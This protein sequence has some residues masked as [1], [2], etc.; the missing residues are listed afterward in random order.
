MFA[1]N[2]AYT[3]YMKRF[4]VGPISCCSPPSMLTFPKSI[5]NRYRLKLKG[6]QAAHGTL[7][8]I[9]PRLQL[10]QLRVEPAVRHERF[11][12]PDLTDA[13]AV[14]HGDQIRHPYRR[15]PVRDKNG[16]GAGVVGGAPRGLRIPRE[17]VMLGLRIEACRRLIQHQEQRSRSHHRPA[18]RQFLLL[19]P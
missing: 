2:C 16:Y 15:E 17:E 5:G 13:P 7:L 18:Q 11:V 14:Q 4:H 12:V 9:R 19:A 1:D 3:Q 8:P 10:V 6:D